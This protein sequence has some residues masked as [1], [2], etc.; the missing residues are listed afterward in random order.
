MARHT[1]PVRECQ[2][3]PSW[4]SWMWKSQQQQTSCFHIIFTSKKKVMFSP[5]IIC[6]LV[7]DGSLRNLQDVLGLPSTTDGRWLLNMY[8]HPFYPH[9]LGRKSE[10]EEQTWPVSSDGWGKML[11]GVRWH[12]I[13]IYR[14]SFSAL[15][16]I[17]SL[18]MLH[19]KPFLGH[20]ITLCY[21]SF[22]SQFGS[23]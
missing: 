22:E 3:S 23:I 19:T 4:M 10:K 9:H 12:S 2:E 21:V 8:L 17:N 11:I 15:S 18:A 20:D 7:R 1:D 5:A 14:C 6:L 13:P 16:C